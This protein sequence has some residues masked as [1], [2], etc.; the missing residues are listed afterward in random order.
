MQKAFT[1]YTNAARPPAVT[2]LK[3]KVNVAVLNVRKGAGVDFSVVEKLNRNDVVTI[4]ETIG[5]WDRIGAD[6]WVK[7]DYLVILS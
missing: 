1:A 4:L 6:K 2:I 5:E 3:G 7:A